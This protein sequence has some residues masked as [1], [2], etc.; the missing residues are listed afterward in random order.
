MTSASHGI[1]L[2]STPVL[3]SL[4]FLAWAPYLIRLVGALPSR[5]VRECRPLRHFFYHQRAQ[6]VGVLAY[7]FEVNGT[8]AVQQT[9]QH[10][11]R[12]SCA[13]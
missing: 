12:S 13:S 10:Q 11:Q 8:R 7:H 9:V 1:V 5:A 6:Q 2:V 4:Q 3:Q